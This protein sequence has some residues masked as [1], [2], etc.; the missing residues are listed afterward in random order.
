MIL[1]K[2]TLQLPD[3]SSGYRTQTPVCLKGFLPVLGM[4]PETL[5]TTDRLQHKGVALTQG[6]TMLFHNAKNFLHD[7]LMQLR[8]RGVSDILFLNRRINKG[9]IMMMVIIVLV[10]HTNAF[11]KNKFNPGFTDTFSEMNQF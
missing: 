9:R 10:I 8:I 11:L 2:I 1:F 7:L 4:I 3:Q 5:V 6:K